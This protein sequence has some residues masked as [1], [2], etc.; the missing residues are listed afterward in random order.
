MADTPPASTAS[1]VDD[2]GG[3]STSI[4]SP[5]K[6]R[7]WILRVVSLLGMAGW[8]LMLGVG[9]VAFLHDGHPSDA[10]IQPPR[11]VGELEF[12][13]SASDV[14]N[15]EGDGDGDLSD[16]SPA[17]TDRDDLEVAPTVEQVL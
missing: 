4:P 12:I 14:A 8:G 16:G 11:T 6:S 7:G 1:P 2:G 5:G 13:P 3:A 9:V 10:T 15:S 17:G